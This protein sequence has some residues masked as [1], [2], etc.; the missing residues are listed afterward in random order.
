[1][2]LPENMTAS[3]IL[4]SI[5]LQPFSGCKLAVSLGFG[6]HTPNVGLF[7]LQ[8]EDFRPGQFLA[9]DAL[10][11]SLLLVPLAIVD[12]LGEKKSSR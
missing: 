11:G 5:Q 12:S 1:V 6:F 4:L 7:P 9:L 10:A 8:P 2:S 3:L